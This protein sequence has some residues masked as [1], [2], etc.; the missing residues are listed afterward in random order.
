M[1]PPWSWLTDYF[2]N[3]YLAIILSILPPF[4]LFFFKD[5]VHLFESERVRVRESTSGGGGR[6]RGRSRLPAPSSLMW[7]LILGSCDHDLSSINWATQGPLGSSFLG[8]FLPMWIQMFWKWGYSHMLCAETFQS[9]HSVKPVD[10]VCVQGGRVS[11]KDKYWSPWWDCW[12][13][14]LQPTGWKESCVWSTSIRMHR[15]C[16]MDS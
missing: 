6:G 5:F 3:L 1:S 16:P 15:P 10:Q 9:E 4:I 14:S 13:G 11:K 8:R 12:H 7:G 2:K